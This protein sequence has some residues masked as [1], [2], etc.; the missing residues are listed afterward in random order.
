VTGP[1]DSVTQVSDD[2]RN[3]Q[4]ADDHRVEQH[5]EGD[6][7]GQLRQEAQRELADAMDVTEQTMSR[8]LRRMARTGYVVRVPHLTD[9]RRHV[10]RLSDAGRAVVGAASDPGPAEAIATHGLSPTQVTVLRELLV[11]MITAREGTTDDE[12]VRIRT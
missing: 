7:E 4:A 1:P 3:E 12:A 9:R 11:T 2:R 10:V 8:V 5:A 6:D